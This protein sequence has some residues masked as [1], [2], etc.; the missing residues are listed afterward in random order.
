[1]FS[2]CILWRGAVNE[3]GYPITWHNNRWAYAHRVIMEAKK[4]EVVMHLC[5]EP[6]CVNSSHLKIGTPA[7]NSADMVRKNRQAKGEDCGNA[8]L[9][10]SQVREIRNCQGFFSSRATG[11]IYNTSHTNVLD[12]WNRRTWRHIED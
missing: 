5:D 11:K 6:R 9:T 8:V 12:I 2:D 3:A 4:G 10:E 7:E 1:M